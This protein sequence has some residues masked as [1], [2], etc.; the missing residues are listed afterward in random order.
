MTTLRPPQHGAGWRSCLRG[1]S[2]KSERQTRSSGS[3]SAGSTELVAGGDEL[4]GDVVCTIRPEDVIV[5]IDGSL[6][7]ENVL[8]ARVQEVRDMG[9]SVRMVVA[10]DGLKL[11]ATV[12]RARYRE[13]RCSVGD[14]AQIALP[15][16]AL[17]MF[18]EEV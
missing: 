4:E 12:T 17:H 14:R 7:G 11:K 16:G 2:C 6:V 1:G 3:P 13:L 9:F 10:T 8:R 18:R 15:P 5:A